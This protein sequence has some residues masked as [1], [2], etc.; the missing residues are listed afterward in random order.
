MKYKKRNGIVLREMLGEYYLFA[1]GEAQN[2]CPAVRQLNETG[3]AIWKMLEKQMD[4]DEMTVS[5][6]AEYETDET[7]IRA[8]IARFIKTMA[9]KEYLEITDEE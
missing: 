2:F 4:E 6:L 1:T 7:Q 8:G 3:A 9:D 5:L